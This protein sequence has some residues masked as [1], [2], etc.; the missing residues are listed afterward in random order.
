MGMGW[1]GAKVAG[2][3]PFAGAGVVLLPN[4]QGYY[5]YIPQC[6]VGWQAVP[7]TPQ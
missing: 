5:P 1:L 2:R 4:P 6:G 7:A 3:A